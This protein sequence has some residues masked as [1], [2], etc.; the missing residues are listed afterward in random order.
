MDEKI[1]ILKK[2]GAI[3]AENFEDIPDLIKKAVG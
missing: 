3:V 1:K 2:S